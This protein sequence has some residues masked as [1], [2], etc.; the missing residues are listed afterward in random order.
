MVTKRKDEARNSTRS[1]ENIEIRPGNHNTGSANDRT[2]SN[3]KIWTGVG[4]SDSRE[5]RTYRR[6][7]QL[8]L[9]IISRRMTEKF[10]MVTDGCETVILVF[11]PVHNTPGRN[12]GE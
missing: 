3:V 7:S 4:P 1:G 5:D 10:T 11:Q 9:M 2:F 12:I 8:V 6:V